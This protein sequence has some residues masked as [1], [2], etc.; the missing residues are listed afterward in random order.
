[1]VN[2]LTFP[3]PIR[4]L[5]HPDGGTSGGD[6]GGDPFVRLSSD[7]HPFRAYLASLEDNGRIV[8]PH[9]VILMEPNEYPGSRTGG[10]RPPVGNLQLERIWHHGLHRHLRLDRSAI[11]YLDT[12]ALAAGDG[13]VELPRH[14]PLAWCRKTG[15]Y[16]PSLCPACLSTM[17]TCRD[18]GLLRKCGLPSYE[19][20]LIRFLHCRRCVTE[21]SRPP[22]FYTYSLRK[23]DGLA[24]G[25]S[26]KRR[27]ELYRDMA[28]RFAGN[29]DAD[30]A[31]DGHPCFSCPHRGD[32]YPAGR[33][34]NDQ[35]PAE[36]QLFPLAYYDFNWLP[37]EPLPLGFH[38]TAALLGGAAPGD[39]ATSSGHESSLC[40]PIL[41]DLNRPG[42]QFFFE[43]DVSGLFALEAL[44]LKLSALCDLARALRDLLA[45]S[46]FGY[47]ALSPDRLRG[48][49][50]SGPSILPT[51]WGLTIK[52][53]DLLTTAPLIELE[54]DQVPGEREVG[55]LPHPCPETFLPEAMGRPQIE[56]LW[57][58][59]NVDEF[60][61]EQ[62]GNQTK[63]TL[64]ARLTAEDVY[65][66][67]DHG[68]HDLVRIVLPLDSAGGTPAIFSGL[69]TGSVAGGFEFTGATGPLSD[70]QAIALSKGAASASRNVEVTIAH[71]FAAPADIISL[72]L[73][74][75]RLLLANDS[76][77]V[78]NLDARLAGTIAETIA[79]ARSTA[80]FGEFDYIHEAFNREKISSRRREVL[81]RKIDRENVD[82]AIPP[83]LWEDT[84]V[85]GLR[86]ASNI[87]D[88]S[89]CANQD[90]YSAEDPQQPLSRI[91]DDFEELLERTRGSLIGSGGR[92]A[93][94][95]A[96]CDDFLSDLKEAQ[97]AG[98]SPA[99]GQSIEETMIVMPEGRRE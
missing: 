48:G 82:A 8:V 65:Q 60:K 29:A 32:C 81:Y 18:E 84:L 49:L 14:P 64:Q 22:V 71:N 68:V 28:P 11:A 88:F 6:D 15:A 59:L 67:V 30:A 47:L 86:L 12:R 74:S 7:A 20:S 42:G 75:L 62:S 39:L 96:V 89:V 57:M 16:V 58:R 87:P 43:G 66:G 98:V 79:K 23:I 80:G 53:G 92:N 9:L 54:A 33:H 44:Y 13:D 94:I 55:S 95:Q 21:T 37:L 40:R 90:D 35:L 24:D 34:V 27:S 73:L 1:M 51:R 52:I 56:N 26:L 17:E 5:P 93:S 70:A 10:A 77:D 25:V 3:S 4:L 76:Q 46:G 78:T 41:S 31:A 72:G 36:D 61:T 38:E 91:V 19:T 83:G 50:V 97:A 69:K 85:L 45:E 99:P 63:A 2:G